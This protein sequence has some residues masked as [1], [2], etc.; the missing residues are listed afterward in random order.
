MTRER[1][2]K[3]KPGVQVDLLLEKDKPVWAREPHVFLKG[4]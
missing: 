2:Q 1:L 3:R 4:L